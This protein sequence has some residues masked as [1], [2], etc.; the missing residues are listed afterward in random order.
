MLTKRKKFKSVYSLIILILSVVVLF[1]VFTPR[2]EVHAETP[3]TTV[4]ETKIG[5]SALYKRLRQIAGRGG[6]ILYDEDFNKETEKCV[7]LDLSGTT[8]SKIADLSGLKNFKLNYTKTL[9]VSNNSLTTIS[10]EVLNCIPKLETLI[11]SGN[12]LTS[13]DLSG[14]YNL[15]VVDASGNLLT[16]FNGFDMLSNGCSIDLS[17]NSFTSMNQITLPE[18]TT[19]TNGIIK[20]YNNN[21]SDFKAVENYTFHLGLQGLSFDET[22]VITKAKVVKYYKSSEV[23]RVK[24]VITKGEEVVYTLKD[25]E[26]TEDETSLPLQVGEYQVEY[27]YIA[28]DNTE[29]PL[30]TKRHQETIDSDSYYNEVKNIVKYYDNQFSKF[31]VIP[32]S[33]T[34]KYVIKGKTYNEEDIAKLKS[35]AQIVLT[36]DDDAEC[37]YKFGE[38][39]TWKKGSTID[40][41]R[42][43]SYFIEVKAV[44]GDYE[45]K[46][47]MI[48]IDASA[49]LAIPSILL[50]LLIVLGAGLLFGVGYPLIKKYVL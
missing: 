12:Q 40:I 36:A 29:Y 20:L 5:D 43:G 15:K 42:G 24:I 26:V 41:T 25:W 37:Y 44:V 18:S 32:T 50:I 31:T 21:I 11:V 46:T 16:S 17:K 2:A 28:N 8:S 27:Y 7:N 38:N 33:P 47:S 22:K 30:S 39:G 4:D 19:G 45:S 9:N 34:F 1:G 10:T 13:L 49:N 14:C 6:T 48:L 23:H 35:K 3:K